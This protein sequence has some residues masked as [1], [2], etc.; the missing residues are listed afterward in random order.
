[1]ITP[2]LKPRVTAV[3]SAKRLTQGMSGLVN[4]LSGAGRQPH[5]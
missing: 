5:A 1:M 4:E 2:T 3:G